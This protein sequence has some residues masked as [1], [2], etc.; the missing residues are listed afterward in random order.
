[1]SAGSETDLQDRVDDRV[2]YRFRT[3]RSSGV[4]VPA[5]PRAASP[6]AA[7]PSRAKAP[8]RVA[9]IGLGWVC[10]HRH[11]PVMDRSRAYDVVGVIDRHAGLAASV[12]RQRGYRRY[13]QADRLS[14]VAWLDEVDAV[15][16]AAAPTSHAGLIEQAVALGKHVLTEKPFTMTLGEGRR[17]VRAAAARDLR[18]AVVHNFQFARSTKRLL[19]DLEA[20]RLGK[21]T[22]INAVQLGNPRRRLPAW[23]DDLPFGLFYDESPHLLYLLRR[24]GGDLEL[25]R[26]LVTRHRD[27]RHTPG[28]IDAY[29]RCPHGIAATLRCNF[30]SPISEWHVMAFGERGLGIVDVFRDIYLFL[31]ND[32]RHD[33]LRVLRTS[34]SAT[35]QHWWQHIVS[36]LP[37]LGGRLFYGNEDVF[38]RFAAAI[39]GDS[40]ALAPIGPD[41]ALGV[42]QLQHA[43][44]A[45]AEEALA[46]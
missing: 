37:H 20:G 32:G 40:D 36:G 11:L 31:P 19:A 6:T 23:Y 17:V 38:A 24:L 15:T 16:I 25:T 7:F 9:A 43:I 34:L 26:S 41:S 28:Q 3:Q 18:L 5:G 13:A 29:F 33:T 27:G 8:V 39:A 10:T 44:M 21:L 1:M 35:A 22:A 42:L 14:D 12:A 2:V 4:A 46:E 45:R 30:D